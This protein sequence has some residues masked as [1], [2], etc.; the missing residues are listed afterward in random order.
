[1]K[2]W[3][4]WMWQHCGFKRAASGKSDTLEESSWM[5]FCNSKGLGTCV[6]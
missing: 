3:F 5:F 1:M 6:G 4:Y 2:N